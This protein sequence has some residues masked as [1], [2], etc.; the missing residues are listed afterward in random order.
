MICFTIN[1]NGIMYVEQLSVGYLEMLDDFRP[2]ARRTGRCAYRREYYK[3][4]GDF[5]P[6]VAR[7]RLSGGFWTPVL[8]S[9]AR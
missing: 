7:D 4:H 6:G 9:R 2:P 1:G 3:V 5:T 8:K